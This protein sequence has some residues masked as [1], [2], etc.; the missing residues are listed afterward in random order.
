MARG[1]DTSNHPGRRA[2]YAT[3]G[4]FTSKSG[5]VEERAVSLNT[6]RKAGN[7]RRSITADPM[8]RKRGMIQRSGGELEG[9]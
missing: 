7:L 8:R 1:E 4:N 3:L 6:Y 9:Y 2:D 5:R